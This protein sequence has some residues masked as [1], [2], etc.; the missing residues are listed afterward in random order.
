[1]TKNKTAVKL[2]RLEDRDQKKIRMAFRT[3]ATNWQDRIF[4]TVDEVIE[5]IGWEDGGGMGPNTF[6]IDKESRRRLAFR[7]G[8][9]LKE[10]GQRPNFFIEALEDELRR[11]QLL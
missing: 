2:T 4:G 8:W 5:G 10:I 3:N 6:K 1:M 7:I 9:R 11:F